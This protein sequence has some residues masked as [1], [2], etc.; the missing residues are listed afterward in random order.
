MTES[1]IFILRELCKYLPYLYI[2]MFIVSIG[3][4]KTMS[5]LALT[6][7]LLA[8]AELI[9]NSITHPLRIALYD[10]SVDTVIRLSIWLLFWCYFYA[11]CVFILEK[12][13]VWLNI[14]KNH[15][16]VVTESLFAAMIILELLHFT[17]AFLLTNSDIRS[18]YHLGIPLISL[19]MGI[20][21]FCQFLLSIK[22]HYVSHSYTPSGTA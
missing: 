6:V 1:L 2:L 18:I 21:L 10:Q 5:S 7:I 9:I 15:T 11:L 8:C 17:T 3:I 19:S 12:S 22:D 16:L 4:H 20:F 13:H 14:S